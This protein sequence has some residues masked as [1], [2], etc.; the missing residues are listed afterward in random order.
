MN[1]DFINYIDVD[2]KDLL[3]NGQ[4]EVGSSATGVIETERDSD[5]FRV[6]LLGGHTYVIDMEGSPTDKG[7]LSDP[8]IRGIKDAHGNHIPL[9]TNDDGGEGY[10][11]KVEFTPEYSGTYYVAAGSYGFPYGDNPTP[12]E[13]G[14]YTMSVSDITPEVPEITAPVSEVDSDSSSGSSSRGGSS[15]GSSSSSSSSDSSSSSSGSSSGNPDLP[16]PR[17]HTAD[18]RHVQLSDYISDFLDVHPLYEDLNFDYTLEFNEILG[19]NAGGTVEGTSGA[20][21]IYGGSGE[22]ILHGG[23]GNDYLIGYSGNDELNGGPGH[24]ELYGGSGTNTLNG[25]GGNDILSGGGGV[26][27]FDGGPGND[28]LQGGPGNDKLYGGPGNDIISGENGSDRIVPG[29]GR[30]VMQGGSG[31]DTFVFDSSDGRNIILDFKSENRGTARKDKFD[32]SATGLTFEDVR[33]E[34]IN[35]D[36]F[37]ATVEQY[38]KISFAGTTIILLNPPNVEITEDHFIV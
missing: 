30:D 27:T 23:P 5:W 38:I 1:D 2:P 7:T 22:D 18:F 12:Y 20:D 34:Q 33:I 10:N 25:D 16:S 4:V 15:R 28:L 21:Y 3:V 14:S 26:D 31:H 24:D 32:I 37:V 9:T 13:L 29:N 19:T 8:A 17:E 36:I 35:F 11:S 6:D